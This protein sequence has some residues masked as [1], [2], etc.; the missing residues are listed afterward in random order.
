MSPPPSI[1]GL[2]QS[3]VDRADSAAFF[4]AWVGAVLA[5]LGLYTLHYPFEAD[6]KDTHGLTWDLEILTDHPYSLQP[7]DCSAFGSVQVEVKSVNLT[8]TEPSDYP[9]QEVLLCSQN[10]FN[11]KWPGYKDTGRD[12]LIVSRTTGHIVWVPYRTPAYLGKEVFDNSR[13]ELYK[14]VWVDRAHLKTVKEFA[15]SVKENGEYFAG[16]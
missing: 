3:F 1:R 15:Q 2:S 12:F 5:R 16:K 8:F 10:S 14:A 6:G 13:G 9:Y 11:R 7:K 4:E